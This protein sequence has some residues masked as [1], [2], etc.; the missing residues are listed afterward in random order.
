MIKSTLRTNNGNGFEDIAGLDGVKAILRKSVLLPMS[1]PTLFHGGRKPWTQ[2]LLFGP[3]GTGKSKMASSLA[4][5][6]N[7]EFYSISSADL[8][9]SWVGESEK[10]IKELFEYTRTKKDKCIVFIDEIDSICRKRTNR[11]G[12]HTRS[13]KNQLLVEFDQN[14]STEA[15]CFVL[16]A[17]NCPWDIDSAFMRRFQ[18][19]IYVPLPD[20]EA[21]LTLMKN[22]CAGINN[23]MSDDDW[24][25]VLDKTEGYS[26][27]DLVNVANYALQEPLGEI[28]N[29]EEWIV[30]AGG[31][32]KPAPANA[33]GSFSVPL[34]SVP[35]DKVDIKNKLKKLNNEH[36]FYTFY[37][38][39]IYIRTD[40]SAER[41]PSRLQ[42]G[43]CTDTENS[44]ETGIRE[45]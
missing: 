45:I 42:Q 16:C 24:N 30:V 23:D 43:D 34:S 35:P 1:F 8:L 3:P 29:N 31:K 38:K 2:I 32:W 28:E 12:D 36:K 5:E 19:R 9:S 15:N 11:E 20:R 13:M 6:A 17:T 39:C 18:R 44:F 10:M 37:N 33:L 26:G 41:M 22:K 27:S 25:S 4:S 40:H 7:A 14:L 21:R